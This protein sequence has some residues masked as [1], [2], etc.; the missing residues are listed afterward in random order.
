[1]T[2]IIL[3]GGFHELIELAEENNYEVVGIIDTPGSGYNGAIKVLCIDENAVNLGTHYKNLPLVLSPDQPKVRERLFSFYDSIGFRFTS[4]V[5]SKAK[6]SKSAAIGEGS[7]I[8]FGVNVSSESSVGCFV[9]LNT[10][11]NVMHNVIIGDFTTIAPNAVILGNINI[12][13]NCYIGSN[14]TILSNL[15]ICNNVIIG[16]GAVVTNNINKPG[17]YIGIPARPITN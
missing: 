8:Q 1:M 10:Y 12:G 5:S 14:S 6:I 13:S 9:R 16:A 7:I 17:T 15:S 11:S 3:V 4:L 2:K